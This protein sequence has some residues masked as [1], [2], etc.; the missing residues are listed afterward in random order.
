LILAGWPERIAMLRT[1]HRTPAV[2]DRYNVND[3]ELLTAGQRLAAYL[4]KN[5]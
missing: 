5:S 3:R 2:F 4:E 1:G